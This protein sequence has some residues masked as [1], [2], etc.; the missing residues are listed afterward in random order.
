MHYKKTKKSTYSFNEA[1]KTC[2]L[3][4][5]C[6]FNALIKQIY[7]K[8]FYTELTNKYAIKYSFVLNIKCIHFNITHI[9]IKCMHGNTCLN[10]IRRIQAI[11]SS[12]K[13]GLQN[14]LSW[15]I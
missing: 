2:F 11:P 1:W 3:V 8:K 7:E 10:K 6:K 15:Q 5:L 9:H 14:R 12:I 4:T 13:S